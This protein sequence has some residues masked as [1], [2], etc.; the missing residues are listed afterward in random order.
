MNGHRGPVS[1]LS[2]EHDEKGY[3]SAGWDGEALVS[4]CLLFSLSDFLHDPFI[5]TIF[6]SNGTSTLVKLFENLLHMALNLSASPL[7]QQRH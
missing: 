6:C 4:C 2:M 3:F 1:A 7:S 5:T